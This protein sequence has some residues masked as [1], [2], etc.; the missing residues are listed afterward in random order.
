MI[1]EIIK[2]GQTTDP[3][4]ILHIHSIIENGE[5]PLLPPGNRYLELPL[6]QP[7]PI[8]FY[9]NAHGIIPSTPRWRH[10]TQQENSSSYN[11]FFFPR[12]P[13][14]RLAQH[15]AGKTSLYLRVPGTVMLGYVNQ[16]QIKQFEN[17][18]HA[19]ELVIPQMILSSGNIDESAQQNPSEP[20]VHSRIE[21]RDKS[22]DTG[23]GLRALEF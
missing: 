3:R 2:I 17:W 1:I 5:E 11:P 16:S 21:T 13:K 15:Y 12:N 14:A 7:I 9:K 4:V 18:Y 19:M 23:I 10:P 20:I 8:A 22:L 6:P